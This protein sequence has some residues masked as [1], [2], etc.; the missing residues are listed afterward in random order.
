[1]TQTHPEPGPH[2]RPALP[3]VPVIGMRVRCPKGHDHVYHPADSLSGSIY[4]TTGEC[5][6]DGCQ[7]DSGSGT[8]YGLE[9]LTMV[10][11][12]AS[13]S[14]APDHHTVLLCDECTKVSRLD[15]RNRDGGTFLPEP[16]ERCGRRDYLN[17]IKAVPAPSPDPT[18]DKAAA[19]AAGED[20]GLKHKLAFAVKSL[21]QIACSAK[22]DQSV[23]RFA[24][25]VIDELRIPSGRLAAAAGAAKTG[26]E[27]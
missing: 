21:E 25:Q 13:P 15:R 24:R 22:D 17:E 27:R 4:C 19:R 6:S 23:R 3:F 8:R 7:G 5:W 14:P 10:S 2:E 26:G 12:P 16:C 11:A 9:Q 18:P 1:M 20:E